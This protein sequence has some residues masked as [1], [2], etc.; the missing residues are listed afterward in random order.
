MQKRWTIVDAKAQ[1]SQIVRLAYQGE[2]QIIGTQKPCIL[3]PEAY[4]NELI[5]QS[6]E[7][8]PPLGL[9]LIQA[10]ALVS[11]DDEFELPSRNNDRAAIQFED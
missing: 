11:L 7:K 9:A 3:I 5:E 8:T 1:L 2:P 10:G 4:F 6:K